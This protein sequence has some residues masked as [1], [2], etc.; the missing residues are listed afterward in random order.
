MRRTRSPCWARAASGRAADKRDEL[1]SPHGLPL[2][3]RVPYHAEGCIV[4]HGKFG[5]LMSA[6][7]H[8]RT[9]HQVRGMS[10]LPP[11]ADIDRAWRSVIAV[12]AVVGN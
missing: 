12:V 10:A 7:G 1:A 4:H 2:K 11:K 3:Q 5:L 9:S 8:K 6:L